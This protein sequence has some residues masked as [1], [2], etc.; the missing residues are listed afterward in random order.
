[1]SYAD[2][3]PVSGHLSAPTANADALKQAIE[4]MGIQ[5]RVVDWI[6]QK[7]AG[8]SLV[9]SIIAPI[10]GD[11]SRIAA[12]GQAWQQVG[13]ALDA[14]S[15]NLTS[16]VGTLR[17]H[18]SGAAAD[19][20]SGH[21]ENV[22]GGGLRG[23]AGIAN[24]IGKGFE[25]VADTSEKM[26]NEA[27]KLLE[28]V[29]NK[30][31]EAII[32]AMIPIVGWAR[33]VKIIWDAY[34]IYQKIMSIIE[35]IKS[36]IEAV[37]GLFDAV[38]QI[39]TAIEQIPDVRNAGDA[40]RVVTDIAGGVVDAG[41]AINDGAEAVQSGVDA[42]NEIG[43]SGNSGDSGQPSGSAVTAGSGSQGGSR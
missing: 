16:N 12:N 14:M 6:F 36:L 11:W 7:I 9:Q 26:G 27:L 20:F 1:M 41:Q 33:A 2:T 3:N 35:A 42:A 4:G 15:E 39:K 21:I 31:I 18:W 5:T 17:Q 34:Q 24:L 38:G 29:I 37:K 40:L 22:W 8:Q 23:H 25:Q 13:Q 43:D 30:C 10:T 28:S 19:S 32:A